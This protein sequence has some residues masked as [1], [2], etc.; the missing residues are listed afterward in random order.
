[1]ITRFLHDTAL[2]LVDVQVGIDDLQHWGGPT[3]RRN[4]P[5]AEHNCERLLA[6]FRAAGNAVVFTLQDSVEAASPL[7][8]ALPTGQLKAG[9]EPRPDEVRVVK[10]VNGAFFGTDLEIELRRRSIRR[11]VVAGFFTNMC[12]ETTVRTAGNLCYDVYLAHDA[13]ATGNRIGIDGT[14]HD[15]EM[16]HDLSVASMHGEFCTA[17][18]TDQVLTLLGEDDPALHRVQGNDATVR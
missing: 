18:T 7:K 3:G 11:L 9:F 17:L 14:D 10:H 15:P 5:H 8:V 6:G 16:V 1:M 2:V 12:V 13:C 4:N